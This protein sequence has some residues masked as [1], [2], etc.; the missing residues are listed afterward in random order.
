MNTAALTR[1]STVAY[2]DT[3]IMDL[4]AALA[5]AGERILISA[6]QLSQRMDDETLPN[7]FDIREIRRWI[8]VAEEAV[9]AYEDQLEPLV[10]MEAAT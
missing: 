5:S 1:K 3:N 9:S 10:E 2:D 8:K 6:G 7:A 4:Y